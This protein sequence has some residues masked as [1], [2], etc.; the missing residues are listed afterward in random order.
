[1]TQENKT[2][3]GTADRELVISRLLDAP[4]ELVWKVWTEPE[5]IAK[6]WGPNGFTNTIDKM[7]VRQGGAWEFMMH[8]PDGTNFKNKSVFTE[9]VKHERIV[10]EHIGPKF[11]ATITFTAQGK[12][13]LLK[14]QMLF[15]S[16]EE[17]E[18]VVKTVKADEGLKQNVE[19]LGNYLAMVMT[20]EPF[21]IERTL[22]ASIEKVWDAITDKDQMKKWYFDL[23]EFKAEVGYEF[24]FKGGKDEAHP[25]LHLCKIIEVIPRKKLTYTWRYDGYE[26]NSFVVF[27]LFA[28]AN[29]TR[30]KLTHAGLETFPANNPDLAKGNFA[31][32]WTH[33]I[34]T[35]LVD[36]IG[37][38]TL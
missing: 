22:D 5:H 4:R 2:Q 23:P 18:Q 17:F 9:V 8:G 14:W 27:E 16:V 38:N 25:Y 24:Q 1:M 35:S 19:K 28:E 32:G 6:W 31:E 34:G 10:F 11:T 20:E 3:S 26:G 15:D 33:I 30:L 13:T 7:E 21:V 37:K 12:K 36:F 29:K